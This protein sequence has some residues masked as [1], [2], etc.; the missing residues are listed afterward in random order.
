M[1]LE[2]FIMS[3]EKQIP[4]YGDDDFLTTQ[5]IAEYFG[6][7]SSRIR[8]L[9]NDLE[10]PHKKAGKYYI[11]QFKDLEPIG[12]RNTDVGHRYKKDEE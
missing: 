6:L 2:S 4:E 10:I 9:I 8:Q 11:I 12:E 1:Q 5:E 3:D 7:T